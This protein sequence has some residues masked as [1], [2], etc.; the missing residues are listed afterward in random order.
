[1]KS[2]VVVGLFAVSCTVLGLAVS[3][4]AAPEVQATG[5]TDWQNLLVV[6]EPAMLLLL[7]VGL[8]L[9]AIRV[10]ARRRT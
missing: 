2:P 10:R 7:G 8:S 5:K 9:L 3:V 4:A 1:M 6:P